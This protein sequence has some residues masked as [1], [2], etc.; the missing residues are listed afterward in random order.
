[1]IPLAIEAAARGAVMGETIPP[2]T[3]RATKP[4]TETL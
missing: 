2:A 4:E 3:P 1:M